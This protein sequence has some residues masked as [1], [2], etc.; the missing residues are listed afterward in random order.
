MSAWNWGS[1][2][3]RSKLKPWIST[4]GG[5]APASSAIS[6]PPSGRAISHRPLDV[7][8][9]PGR[10]R[11]P[12]CR[13]ARRVAEDRDDAPLADPPSVVVAPGQHVVK[14]GHQVDAD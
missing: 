7:T 5:P 6:S 4:T 8:V 3:D 1:H 9:R 2:I 13:A 14:V 10:A 11:G 12:S